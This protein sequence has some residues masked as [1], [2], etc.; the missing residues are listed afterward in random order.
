MR[1]A[2]VMLPL[3]AA[4]HLLGWWVDGTFSRETYNLLLDRFNLHVEGTVPAWFSAALL[5]TIGFT[6]FQ[7][8]DLPDVRA[9]GD[10]WRYRLLAAAF[11]YVSCDES[12]GLHELAIDPIRSAFNLGGAL[13]YAWIVPAVVLLATFALL[14]WPIVPR[15]TP[16]LRRSALLAGG[17]YLTGAIGMEM[18][19]GL[20]RDG[21]DNTGAA[22]LLASTVE[23][24]LEIIGLLVM[25]TAL[26]REGAASADTH[27]AEPAIT[28]RPQPTPRIHIA[29]DMPPRKRGSTAPPEPQKRRS[30]AALHPARL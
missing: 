15:M 25:V 29:P 10:T 12:I 18:V 14:L 13:Y 5:L 11:F 1:S 4:M 21:G 6:W 28:R 3:L 27:P 26:T 30:P 9:A 2:W 19:G 7:R 16:A 17:I 22:Y 20:L 8:A 23:E 24:L